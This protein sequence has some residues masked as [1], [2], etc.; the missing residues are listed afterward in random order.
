MLRAR[1]TGDRSWSDL[2]KNVT[3]LLNNLAESL[4]QRRENGGGNLHVVRKQVV[5][6]V[7]ANTQELGLF[8]GGGGHGHRLGIEQRPRAEYVVLPRH[9]ER[10]IAA[11]HL[12]GAVKHDVEGIERL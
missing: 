4:Y 1:R 9:G 12:H 8:G 6:I 7:A 2:R 5:K 10:G 3:L 11:L